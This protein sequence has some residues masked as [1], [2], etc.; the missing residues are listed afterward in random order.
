MDAPAFDATRFIRL[1]LR[2]IV[3]CSSIIVISSMSMLK[4]VY[5]VG[6]V[7]PSPSPSLNYCLWSSINPF[8]RPTCGFATADAAC[9]VVGLTAQANGSCP[10]GYYY[11]TVTSTFICPAN[12][13]TTTPPCI[14]TDPYV[15]DEPLHTSCVLPACPDHASRT[16]PGAACTCEANYQFDATGTSCV[17]T[18]PVPDL[19]AP[20]FNDACAESLDAGLGVDVNGKCPKLS[21]AMNN[22]IQCFADKITAT[23]AT[24]RTPIPYSGPTATIRNA[25]YQA[26]LREIWDKLIVLNNLSDPAEISACQPRRDKVIAEKG[27]SSS[28]KC[29]GACTAGSHCLRNIPATDSNHPKGTAFDVPNDTINGLL[30]ELTPLPPTPMT[31]PQRKQAWQIW[32]A[33]WLEK[34]AACNLVWGG[35]FKYPPGPDFIHFQMP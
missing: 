5:A 33:D 15:P 1:A 24:M 30:L 20:P 31:T 17:S 10:G 23:N 25:A 29:K 16:S 9:A 18:C 12:T 6:V 26:H 28:K 11:W 13:T 27:C 32:V 14:C 34:P 22:Q 8:A 35:S 7:S 4:L 3:F 21:D 19:T 2:S